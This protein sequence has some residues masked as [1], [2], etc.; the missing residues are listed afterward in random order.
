M[1]APPRKA[2]GKMIRLAMDVAAC[3]VFANAP[4]SSPM[5]MNASVPQTISGIAIHQD[6]VSFRPK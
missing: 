1:N 6:A 4:T 5:D 3:C 2:I